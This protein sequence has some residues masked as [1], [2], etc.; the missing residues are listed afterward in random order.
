MARWPVEWAAEAARGNRH[1]SCAQCEGQAHR[2]RQCKS[3]L[4]VEPAG[5]IRRCQPAGARCRAGALPLARTQVGRRWRQPSSPLC[6]HC[7]GDPGWME[8]E[9][10]L[11]HRDL[12]FTSKRVKRMPPMG[13]HAGGGVAWTRKCGTEQQWGAPLARVGPHAVD[14]EDT[15]LVGV[16]AGSRRKFEGKDFVRRKCVLSTYKNLSRKGEKSEAGA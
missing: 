14:A 7:F 5:L 6:R 12:C 13:S 4:C 8:S 15:H 2:H 11:Q 1:T 16:A 9:V 3:K 10:V